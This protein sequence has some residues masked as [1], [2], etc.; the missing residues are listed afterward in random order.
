MEVKSRKFILSAV[1]L[2]TVTLFFVF[3]LPV[4][5]DQWA[6]FTKWVL[7]SYLG[8]NVVESVAGKVSE[9]INNKKE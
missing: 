3:K 8:A 9:A 1:I 6:E 4:T 2:L 7:V 5:F